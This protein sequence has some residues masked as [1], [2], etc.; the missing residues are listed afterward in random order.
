MTAIMAAR[1]LR[2]PTTTC[3]LPQV[4]E[5]AERQP[6]GGLKWLMQRMLHDGRTMALQ[7]SIEDATHSCGAH[8]VSPIP[9]V[10]SPKS[11]TILSP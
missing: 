6:D 11:S 9:V 3:A 5:Y 1:S 7:L 2:S 10:A 8:T 4:P